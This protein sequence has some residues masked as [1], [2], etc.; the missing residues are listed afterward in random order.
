MGLLPFGRDERAVLVVAF[1]VIA[2]AQ[3]L[4]IALGVT[5]LGAIA[6]LG[7]RQ[8]HRGRLNHLR[9]ALRRRAPVRYA[10]R[11]PDPIK[12]RDHP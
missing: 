6:I 2:A 8:A 10:R 1:V 5:V 7:H 4:A 3:G 9:A 12:K 11:V